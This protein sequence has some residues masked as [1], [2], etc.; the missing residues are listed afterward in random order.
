MESEAPG[1]G[2]PIS[3]AAIASPKKKQK[4]KGA[5]AVPSQQTAALPAP[6]WKPQQNTGETPAVPSSPAEER[7]APPWKPQQKA[8]AAPLRDIPAP[9][10][11]VLKAR[12]NESR[13]KLYLALVEL[14][15]G[16]RT[17]H[18]AARVLEDVDIVMSHAAEKC[19]FANRL[20][21]KNKIDE[22]LHT[23]VKELGETWAQSFVDEAVKK[24]CQVILVMAGFPC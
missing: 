17:T 22:I 9:K 15:A 11:P 1:H 18:L 5:H 6:P 13:K 2:A 12:R 8:S 14:F 24:E 10:V 20:A 16:L 7:T 19:D 4:T 3:S 23:D 21:E